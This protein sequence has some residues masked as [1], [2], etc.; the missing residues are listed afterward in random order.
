MRKT[1]I[2][3]MVLSAIVMLVFGIVYYHPITDNVVDSNGFWSYMYGSMSNPWVVYSGG[4][5]FFMGLTVFFAT[6]EQ[7]SQRY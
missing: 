6:M 1:A 2:F 3:I 4:V 7:K 5:V